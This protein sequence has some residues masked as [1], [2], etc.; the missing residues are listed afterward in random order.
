M[1]TQPD[2]LYKYVD[3][4]SALATLCDSLV[5]ADRIALDTEADS[6]HHYHEKVCLIQLTVSGDH[7]IVDPLVG[8]DIA[9][10]LEILS[11]KKLIFHS[12][13]YDL[14]MLRQSFGFEVHGEVFDTLVAAQLLGCEQLGLVA[15]ADRFLGVSLTKQGQK[16]D[17]S[18]RPL[19][20]SQLSYACDDTRYLAS[21]ADTLA[22]ELE[23]LGRTE[24]HRESCARQIVITA[25]VNH[26]DEDRIWRIKGVRFLKPRQMAFVR[27]IWR[28]RESE[29]SRADIPA[30]KIMLNS[31]ILELAVWCE[32]NGDRIRHT[33]P[34]LPQHCN[35]R[36]LRDLEKAIDQ[37]K[38]APEK[39]WPQHIKGRYNGPPG[40][41][42]EELR[43]KCTRIANE[44]QI[45]QGVLAPRATL[46]AIAKSKP[47]TVE[48]IMEAGPLMRWQ[49]GLLESSINRLWAELDS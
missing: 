43:D 29:A 2:V 3:T 22:A 44:L 33:G 45:D 34:A 14:R 12:A 9:P 18:R 28:W 48:E 49:A 38:Q 8:L 4:A 17:W 6:L 35:G 25:V 24:W 1:A 13:E 26:R 41:G 32:A 21:L 15:L 31:L 5:T 30:F 40:P 10:L 47:K 16:S 19:T 11:E 37:A 20:Q 36:R 27:E 39:D 23:K 46:E 42:F 7:Y